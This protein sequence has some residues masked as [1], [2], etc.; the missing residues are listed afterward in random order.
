MSKARADRS[1]RN[2]ADPRSDHD[3]VECT[4]AQDL[5]SAELDGEN[6]PADAAELVVHLDG[7][8]SCRHHRDQLAILHRLARLRP[9]EAVPDLTDRIVAAANPPRP[10]HGEWI[11]YSL[12]TVGLTQLAFSTPSLFGHGNGL[13]VHT[14]RHLGSL[15]AAFAIGLVYVAWR[16]VRAFGLLPLAGALAGCLTLTAVV[17]VT[18]GRAHMLGEA[19]HVLDVAGLVLLWLLAGAPH[20]RWPSRPGRV[21]P[22]AAER[23]AKPTADAVVD[24]RNHRQ[25]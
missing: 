14:A 2:Q 4:R 20:P 10:G 12:L 23:A 25:P 13:A 21:T 17:D 3:R 5:I 7:C 1:N 16:P 24:L 9:A 15:A 8:P 22:T 19:H 11:R 18:Q 6:D